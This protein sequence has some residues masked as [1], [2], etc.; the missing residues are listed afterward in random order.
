MP[1]DALQ[2][3][4]AAVAP[5]VLVSAAGLLFNGFQA[6]NLHLADRIRALAAEMRGAETSPGRRRQIADQLE[7]FRRR[8]RLSQSSLEL[9]Y[10]SIL[11]FVI[12]ALLLASAMWMPRLSHPVVV[13]A[14]F[15]AGVV[16]LL[17]SVVLEFVEMWVGLRTIDIEIRDQRS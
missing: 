3:L 13:S 11:C 4:T 16:L 15:V 12:T 5:V 2:S 1:D 10:L 6:K 17:A 14:V 9:I 7:L 8:I